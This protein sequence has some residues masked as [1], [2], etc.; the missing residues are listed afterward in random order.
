VESY[1]NFRTGLTFRDV[2]GILD[3]E[4]RRKYDNGEYMWITR[5][6]VLGKWHEIK[7]RMYREEKEYIESIPNK[8]NH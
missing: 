3:M 8:Y 1:E 7:L 2:R 6:T 4:K 5:H